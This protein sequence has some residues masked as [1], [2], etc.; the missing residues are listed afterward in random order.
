[1]YYKRQDLLE[2]RFINVGFIAVNAHQI[3]TFIWQECFFITFCQQY[4]VGLKVHKQW[5]HLFTALAIIW[6]H[7]MDYNI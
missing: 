4:M 2:S 1:M 3:R 6:K 5:V 7:I